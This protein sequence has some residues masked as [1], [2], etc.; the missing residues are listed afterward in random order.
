MAI[1]PAITTE[2]TAS[3]TNGK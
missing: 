1:D 3:T 2:Y